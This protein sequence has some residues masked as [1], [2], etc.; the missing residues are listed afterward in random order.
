MKLYRYMSRLEIALLLHGKTLKNTT[1][2]GQ[3][4]GMQAQQKGSVLE[5]ATK[6]RLKRIYVD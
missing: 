4:R 5:L 3:A 1:D 6:N 2:H